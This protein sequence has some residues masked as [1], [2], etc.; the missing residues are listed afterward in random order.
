MILANECIRF[1]YTL[2]PEPISISFMRSCIEKIPDP[3]QVAQKRM[4]ELIIP[5]LLKKLDKNIDL[6]EQLRMNS[7]KLLLETNCLQP[8]LVRLNPN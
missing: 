5:E 7:L 2:K 3:K 8:F 1:G 6:F 4:H